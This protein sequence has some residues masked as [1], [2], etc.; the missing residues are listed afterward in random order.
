MKVLYGE[1]TIIGNQKPFSSFLPFLHY[2]LCPFS[3][4]L[5]SIAPLINSSFIILYHF[6]RFLHCLDTQH[7][8]C[9]SLLLEHPVHFEA[10][11]A[12]LQKKPSSNTAAIV[13]FTVLVEGS[14]DSIASF[15]RITSWRRFL[16]FPHSLELL[17]LG[18]QEVI[19]ITQ[20]SPLKARNFLF[21]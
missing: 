16:Y 18:H 1:G 19:L 2:L 17:S 13:S 10:S 4:I 7:S 21:S 8:L 5:S 3:S 11:C 12:A 14:L 9:S 6:L 15:F 20:T